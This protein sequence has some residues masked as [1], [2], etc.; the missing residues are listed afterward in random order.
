MEQLIQ[1]PPG[2]IIN[3][4]ILHLQLMQKPDGTD[5]PAETP[6]KQ[7][8]G[9]DEWPEDDVAEKYIKDGGKK[10]SPSKEDDDEMDRT[11]KESEKPKK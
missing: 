4:Y 7:E 8:N 5:L 11:L 1:R 10:E 6:P 2:H 9:P 3:E